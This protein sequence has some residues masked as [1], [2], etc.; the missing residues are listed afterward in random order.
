MESAVSPLFCLYVFRSIFIL[1]SNC[2]FIWSAHHTRRR[3][4]FCQDRADRNRPDYSGSIPGSSE[5]FRTFPDGFRNPNWNF[6]RS[7]RIWLGNCPDYSGPSGIFRPN[8]DEFRTNCKMCELCNLTS[9]ISNLANVIPIWSTC[10]ML[11]NHAL[12]TSWSQT[13]ILCYS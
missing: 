7:P 12:I 1:F 10:L 3:R 11:S 4:R 13:F 9:S 8:P 5:K 6:L 2:N